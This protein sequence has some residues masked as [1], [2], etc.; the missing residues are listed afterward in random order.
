MLA[1]ARLWQIQKRL[2]A[3]FHADPR[4]FFL[5]QNVT[6]AMNVFILGMPLPMGSE[7]LLSDLEYQAVENICR[8]RAE[9]DGL[10]MRKFH[11]PVPE[12]GRMS[13]QEISDLVAS[14]LRPETGLLVLS[15]VFTGNGMVLPVAEIA[16]RTREQGVLFAVDGAHAA[17]ALEL[18]FGALEHLDF[19]G[20]NLHKWMLGPKGTG[21][22][23]VSAR[24]HE[25]LRPLEA[26]WSTFESSNDYKPFG[27]GARFPARFLMQG[28]RN[29]GPF[30][31]IEDMLAFWEKH[32]PAKIRARIRSLQKFLE[33]E[34]AAKLDWPLLSPKLD[35]GLRGPLTTYALPARLEEQGYGLMS[36]L[37]TEHG[38]QISMTRMQG[39]WRMRLSPHVYITEEDI[40]RAVD[41]LRTE[42]S[43]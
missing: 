14:E 39:R 32:T 13:A 20:S 3:F 17:G 43:L 27:N 2:A 28:C 35:G 4:S 40:S 18:D 31:A 30:F 7:I 33:R 10:T 42:N 26:G 37:L 41:I 5:R 9:R 21:F 8:Y 1:W 12:S 29:F 15:H 16:A 22:G 11:I 6:E 23:W 24:H 34:V 25:A 36:R 19:Y 38:L